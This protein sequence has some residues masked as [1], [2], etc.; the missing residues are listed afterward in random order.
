MIRVLIVDDHALVRTG[1]RLVL[2][3]ERDIEVVGECATGE[4]AWATLRKVKPDVLLC[5]LHLPGISGL[6]VTE[7]VARSGMETKVLIVSI[8]EDGPLPRRLIEAGAAGYIG[9]GCDASELVRAVRDV[10]RGR[11][12]LA[13]QV[14]QH[15][16]FSGLAGPGSP[17]DKLSPRELEV[18]K[19]LCTGMR[20]EE[21]GRR[22]SLSGKTV[23][24]H[25]Y[26]L[27]DKLGIKDA[28]ALARLAA[29]HGVSDPAYSL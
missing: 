15:L 21:I 8:Q 20:M 7:R 16:A 6:D 5:D 29:Q 12:Y 27:F 3:A 17:F 23:A 26:R 25:K 28:I 22:L 14:A 4:E 1:L 11:R 24:T 13:S 2:S 19:M 9:K 10:A 18:A